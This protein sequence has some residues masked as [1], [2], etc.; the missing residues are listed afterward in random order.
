MHAIKEQKEKEKEEK[1]IKKEK[2]RRLPKGNMQRV[3]VAG[4]HCIEKEIIH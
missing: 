3:Y 4:L 2:G 1:M